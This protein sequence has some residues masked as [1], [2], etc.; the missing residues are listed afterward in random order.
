[1]SV[2]SG[3]KLALTLV[4]DKPETYSLEHHS[5][6]FVLS[7]GSTPTAHAFS[8]NAMDA[9]S[10]QLAEAGGKL[11]L[12]AGN[13]PL[14]DLQQC[15]TSLIGLEDVA[16]RILTSVIAYYPGRGEDGSDEAMCDAGGIAMS[17]DVG[18]LPGFGDVI[19]SLSPGKSQ[20]S[21]GWRIGRMSQEHGILTRKSS[22]E[23]IPEKEALSLGDV[24][25]VVG[26]HACMIAAA[27][28]WY[29]VVDSTTGGEEQRVVDVWV[30]WKGW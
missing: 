8:A 28:P 23:A 6:P 17:K 29:Y 12:H 10:T 3:A 2:I 7:V 24:V 27:Y 21:M 13:Y 18:P 20:S 15:A 22:K 14:C 4:N 16:Q 25:E 11:E 19:G 9:L 30:P 5:K 26:Q 1:M